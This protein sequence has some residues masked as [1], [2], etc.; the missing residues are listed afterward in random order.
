MVGHLA[1]GIVHNINGPLQI[2]SMQMEMF[3][4]DIAK[5]L[6]AIESFLNPDVPDTLAE[7]L[8]KLAANFQNR[9][10][11]LVQMEEVLARI[12]YFIQVITGRSQAEEDEQRP[13]V[14]NKLLEEELDFWM[15]DLFFKHKVEKQMDLPPSAPLIVINENRLR[16][17]IDGLL[18]ACIEQ[19]REV[20]NRSLKVKLCQKDGTGWSLEFEHTGCAFPTVRKQDFAEYPLEIGNDGQENRN[21]LLLFLALD[22]A[23][24]RAEQI[25]GSFSIE[26]QKVA[27]LIS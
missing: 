25:G 20:E 1:K 21:D 5:D 17:L 13:V 23:R 14:L 18:S 4:M 27:C 8:K 3:K 9:T 22:L 6:K 26:P 11:R 16:D 19:M 7:Q 2:L 15:A 10:E 12:E 24:I